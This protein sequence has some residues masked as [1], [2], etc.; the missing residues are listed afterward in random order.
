M[1][2]SLGKILK[3]GFDKAVETYNTVDKAVDEQKNKALSA[4]EN[5]IATIGRKKKDDPSSPA[6]A[7][8]ETPK[9]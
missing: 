9:P 8:P 1:G 4:L 7:Q 2:F 5:K 6:P 3:K